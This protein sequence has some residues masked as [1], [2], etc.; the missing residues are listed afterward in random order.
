MTKFNT[1]TTAKTVNAEGYTAYKM[2]SKTKLVTQVMTSFINE[3]KFYGDNT[4]EIKDTIKEVIKTDPEF[5]SNLA[6]FA[7]REFN[8]RSVSHV[9]VGFLANIKEGKPYVKR[10]IKGVTLRGDDITEILA[11]YLNEFGKPIPNSLRR[12]LKDV[13]SQLDAYSLAKYKAT[14]KSVKMRDVLCLCRP[15]PK[16]DE[17]SAM[18]KKLLEGTLEPPYTWETELSAKGNTK[19]VWENLIASKKLPYMAA[20]RN[21][22]NIVKVNPDNLN[23]YLDFIKNPEAVRKSKQLPFRYLSAYRNNINAETKVLD[24]LE[25]AVDV[26]IENLP[27]IPGKT[28]IAIDT[29]G[30]MSSFTSNKSEIRC[31]D[32]AMMLGL[33]ANKICEDAIVFTFNNEINRLSVSHRS[34]ILYATINESSCTGGTRMSLPFTK[35][36]SNH[37]NCDRIIILSDNMC[38]M[39]SGWYYHDETVQVLADEYRK[40]TGNDIWVHAI[41]L[42]GYGTQQFAGPKTNIIAGWS[43][44]IFDFI[45][46]AEQGESTLENTLASYKWT[47]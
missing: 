36:I 37:I 40:K 45:L 46:M 6:V 41:D 27:K 20:L 7:R 12:G 35:M 38:N 13:F 32:I 10:T 19:E 14:N 21:C 47:M 4:E 2:N 28:V 39:R 43:E 9:L 5:V 25:N 15:T 42:Q 3:A 24:A 11:F 33:I 34:G 23:D 16:S 1:I 26:S 29:S 18:W 44:K 22:R 17:Q 31:C 30:S 8:M